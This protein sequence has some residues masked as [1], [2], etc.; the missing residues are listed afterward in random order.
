MNTPREV[1]ES[2]VNG[3]LEGYASEKRDLV[4]RIA[5]VIESSFPQMP[6]K[7]SSK[8]ACRI[9]RNNVDKGSRQAYSYWEGW[10]DADQW[11]RDNIV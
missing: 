3:L 1:A 7:D 9:Q 4:D 11:I 6:D 5:T 10:L 8:E 2:I